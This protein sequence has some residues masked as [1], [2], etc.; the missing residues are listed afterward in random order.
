[1]S[2]ARIRSG[3]PY[4]TRSLAICA[5]LIY[6]PRLAFAQTTDSAGEQAQEAQAVS[7]TS[8]SFDQ[9][10]EDPQQPSAQ[11]AVCGLGHLGQCLKDIGHDQPGIWTSPLHI[12]PK[13]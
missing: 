13:D 12:A 2:V 8:Q 10:S 3:F 5:V 7:G 11:S 4:F 6:G 1:M 9:A